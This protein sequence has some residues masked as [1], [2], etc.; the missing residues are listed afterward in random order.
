MTE[1]NKVLEKQDVIR[2]VLDSKY[3]LNI[4][5]DVFYTNSTIEV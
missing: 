1:V 5:G 3:A 2:T 4:V